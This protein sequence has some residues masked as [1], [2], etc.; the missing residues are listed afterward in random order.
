MADA[1]RRFAITEWMGRRGF[2]LD[3]TVLI[4]AATSF[5]RY[6]NLNGPHQKV[7]FNKIRLEGYSCLPESA[8]L[9]RAGTIR[10]T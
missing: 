5:T 3:V 4:L 9:N 8:L 2:R 7:E 6:L 10:V 1:R